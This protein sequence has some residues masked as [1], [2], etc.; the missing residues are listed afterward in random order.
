MVTESVPSLSPSGGGSAH[1]SSKSP[2]VQE[3]ARGGFAFRRSPKIKE[4][5]EKNFPGKLTKHFVDAF[6][7]GMIKMLQQELDREKKQHERTQQEI[8]KKLAECDE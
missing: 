7:D 2:G 6:M 4:F 8:R 1:G 3:S 5:L